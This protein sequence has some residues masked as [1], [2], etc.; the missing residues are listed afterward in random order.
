MSEKLLSN[1]THDRKGKFMVD[2][3]MGLPVCNLRM[4]TA[5][6]T[7]RVYCNVNEYLNRSF[8]TRKFNEARFLEPIYS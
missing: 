6:R 4:Y 5:T 2:P 1:A 3:S 7:T 8:S